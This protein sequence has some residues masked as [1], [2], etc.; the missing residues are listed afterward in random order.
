[1]GAMQNFNAQKGLLVTWHEVTIQ[2]SDEIPNQA[3][4]L[5]I[6]DRDILVNKL[7]NCYSTLS[8]EIKAQIPLKRSW[9]L[10]LVS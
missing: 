8:D 1:M 3:F 2:V 4:N 6:W 7:M 10:S 9:S 5:E